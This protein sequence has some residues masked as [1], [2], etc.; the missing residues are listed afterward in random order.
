[1]AQYDPFYR[2]PET[3][4]FGIVKWTNI[5]TITESNFW[6]LSKAD[7]WQQYPIRA[8][9]FRRF[10]TLIDSTDVPDIYR[11]SYMINVDNYMDDFSGFDGVVL[12]NMAKALN[13]SVRILFN[14]EKYGLKVNNTSFNGK[15]FIVF[16]FTKKMCLI[17][18]KLGALGDLIYDRADIAINSR[19][20]TDYETNEIEF[21]FPILSD[22]FCVIAPSAEKLPDWTAIFR[23]FDKSAWTI[24]VVVQIICAIVW[25][26]LRKQMP[27]RRG[28]NT[29]FSLS[30]ASFEM[31]KIFI[32]YPALMPRSG[33]EM[34]FIASCLIVNLIITGA[35]RVSFYRTLYFI[36]TYINVMYIV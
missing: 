18:F 4:Q 32:S 22:R 2:D 34:T 33:A 19:F 3:G 10:P 29:K 13:F 1:M 31:Y 17:Y 23:C 9:M 11:K 24:I 20:L 5:D 14:V 6:L 25:F 12:G 8:T 7:D 26:V 27:I 30:S 16:R 36:L 15:R 28:E 21:L 35:F